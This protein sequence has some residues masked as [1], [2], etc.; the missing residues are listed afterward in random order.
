MLKVLSKSEL[1]GA[2]MLEE[3]LQIMANFGLYDEEDGDAEER[4]EED[5]SEG[6]SSPERNAESAE[7]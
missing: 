7:A 4:D 6:E 3:L 2:I 5:K 1:D